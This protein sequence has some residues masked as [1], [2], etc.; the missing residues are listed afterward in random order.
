[1]DQVRERVIAAALLALSLCGCGGG[2][3]SGGSSPC[4]FISCPGPIDIT[5]PPPPPQAGIS[6]FFQTVQVGTSV[7]FTALSA[8]VTSPSYAWCRVARGETACLALPDATGPSYTIP[9]PGLADDGAR[10]RV[11]VSGPEGSDASDFARLNVS[12]L[13]GV[14]YVDGEFLASEWAVTSTVVRPTDGTATVTLYRMETYGN[15]GAFQGAL[16]DLPRT[17]SSVAH[18]YYTRLAT[19]YYPTSQGAILAI[20]FAEDCITQ[21]LSFGTGVVPM[22]EQG[23]RRF[24]ASRSSACGGGGWVSAQNSSVQ[25]EDF[26]LLDGPPCGSGESC[27]DFSG[28][29]APIRFGLRARAETQPL[30]AG[31]AG[32]TR[33]SQGIDN[34]KVTVWR[35]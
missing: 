12:P 17:Q 14:V 3:G 33:F 5:W 9:G 8:N 26:T 23:G 21:S 4:I 18:I 24:L 20:D 31:S 29:A 22:V 11:T 1:M 25:R 10:F 7:T 6:P 35:R 15:P 30:P 19:T 32:S 27:P 28:S 34:W 2:G 16:F 13:P